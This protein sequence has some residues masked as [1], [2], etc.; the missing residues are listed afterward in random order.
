[1]RQAQYEQRYAERQ[2]A[3]SRELPFRRLAFHGARSKRSPGHQVQ[4]SKEQYISG[5]S[6]LCKSLEMI[7]MNFCEV[8]SM[9]IGVDQFRIR[10]FG[11]QL[12]REILPTKAACAY[13]EDGVIAPHQTRGDKRRHSA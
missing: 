6:C 9:S 8:E 7:V 1:M 12:V 2:R 10:T 4:R 5:K 13:T 11:D 3:N